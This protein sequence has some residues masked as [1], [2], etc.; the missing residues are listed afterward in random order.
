MLYIVLDLLTNTTHGNWVIMPPEGCLIVECKCQ[1][2][3]GILEKST[4]HSNLLM[5]ASQKNGL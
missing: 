1:N 3:I 5:V 4:C 2:L